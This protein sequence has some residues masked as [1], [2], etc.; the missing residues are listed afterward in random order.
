MFLATGSRDRLIHIF[1]VSSNYTHLCTID[2]HSASITA[3]NFTSMCPLHLLLY[4]CV[5]HFINLLVSRD[6]LQL[7]SC[8]ADKSLM[9][10]SL[11]KSNT[12][13]IFKRTHHIAEKA[14]M[15]DMIVDPTTKFIATASQDK[16][17]R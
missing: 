13:I 17:L 8:G 11:D 5:Y 10:H 14:S 3:V 4:L 7:F 9:F 12:D 1:D 2:D 6:T 15:Y 16:L